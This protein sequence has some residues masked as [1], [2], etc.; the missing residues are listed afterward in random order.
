M[1]KIKPSTLTA[2][3]LSTNINY[4]FRIKTTNDS[5]E[6]LNWLARFTSELYQ[7][8]T[9]WTHEKIM[10]LPLFE[11]FY[12]STNPNYQL[13]VKE[14]FGKQLRSIDKIGEHSTLAITESYPT[15]LHFYNEI[16]KAAKKGKRALGRFLKEIKLKNG[17]SLS[18]NT[19]N[20][21]Q[22]LFLNN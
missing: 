4:G 5:V 13:T 11:H 3:L 6:T 21:V 20:A 12:Q 2:S 17:N 7:E 1:T 19:R 9:G 22:K 14:V 16:C 10:S 8:I 18:K 15:P